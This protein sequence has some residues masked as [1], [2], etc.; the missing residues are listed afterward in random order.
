MH[1]CDVT[2]QAVSLCSQLVFS[3]FLTTQD[4]VLDRPRL[5][6][7]TNTGQMEMDDV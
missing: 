1:R 7:D 5:H 4:P 3:S 2:V 6:S